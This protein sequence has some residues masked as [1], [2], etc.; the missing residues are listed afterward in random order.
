MH[1]CRL[2]FICVCARVRVR[3]SSKL[4][5]LLEFHHFRVSDS[6]RC[7][8]AALNPI[9]PRPKSTF[10]IPDAVYAPRAAILP[11]PH[12]TTH[13]PITRDSFAIDRQ[14]VRPMIFQLHRASDERN[15]HVRAQTSKIHKIQMSQNVI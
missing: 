7:A 6:K 15:Y 11:Q 10:K 14:R 8:G 3:D 13:D 4:L 9:A 12:K 5:L 1:S 2:I